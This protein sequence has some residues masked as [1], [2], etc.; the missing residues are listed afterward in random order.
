MKAVEKKIEKKSVI[1]YLNLTDFFLK[2][3][4]VCNSTCYKFS[5]LLSQLKL[6]IIRENYQ[7]FLS[8]FLFSF[9][10]SM[11]CPLTICKSKI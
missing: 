5:K 8:F 11:N 10:F 1:L 9:I 2:F 4:K 3:V 7:Q 6:H